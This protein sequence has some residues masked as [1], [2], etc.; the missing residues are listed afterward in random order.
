M[1]IK[2]VDGSV[3]LGT[4]D[5]TELLH[6]APRT[7]SGSAFI[8]IQAGSG[9]SPATESGIKLT[10]SGPWGFQ[11]VHM[12]LPDLLKVKH[13]DANGSVDKD[14]IMIWHP[15]GDVQWGKTARYNFHYNPNTWSYA[16]NSY[17]TTS[18]FWSVSYYFDHDGYVH[19]TS[20]GHWARKDANNSSHAGGNEAFYA[21]ISLNNTEPAA[22][23]LYDNFSGG[24][25]SY[26][27]F[28]E[29][30]SPDATGAGS[31]RD[32]NYAAVYK[33][34]AGWNS[35]SLRVTPYF[36]SSH[37]LNINGSGL[38]GFYIPKHYL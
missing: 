26:Q 14:N 28:H 17:N 18:N 29:Y 7:S 24:A 9:G 33:V 19:V 2:N 1:T 6:I 10:E 35:F 31:W 20:H 30:W 23:S 34:S 5:P 3:G 25:S 12:S 13:Q 27:K 15:N 11:L 8:R 21:W 22:S 38:N 32:F 16:T 4:T 37:Y 36:S